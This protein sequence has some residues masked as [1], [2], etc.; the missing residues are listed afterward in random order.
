MNIVGDSVFKQIDYI[1]VKGDRGGF[2][3]SDMF[4]GECKSF[5]RCFGDKRNPALLMSCFYA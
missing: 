1:A 5:S 2:A 4:V 3:C